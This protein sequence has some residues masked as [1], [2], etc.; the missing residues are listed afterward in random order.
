MSDT[1]DVE[2][3]NVE[4]GDVVQIDPDSDGRFGGCLLTVDELKGW[5]VCGFVT[6]P[7]AAGPQV[8]PYRA[9]SGV[10]RRIGRAA[11]RV[12]EIP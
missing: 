7:S 1:L 6:A 3:A 2:G 4:V 11:F 12:P 8:Y 10:I 9:E 5:G